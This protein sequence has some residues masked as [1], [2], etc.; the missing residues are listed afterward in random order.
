[1]DTGSDGRLFYARIPVD[2]HGIKKNNRP[3]FVTKRGYGV[4]GTTQKFKS[5]EKDLLLQLLSHKNRLRITQPISFDV[6]CMFIFAYSNY[7]TKEGRR[8]KHVGD[9]S[10]ALELPQD[11]LEESGIIA[12]DNQICSLDGSRRIYAPENYLEIFIYPF[13]D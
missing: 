4:L 2:K 3:I 5:L 1:M 13:K 8:S 11:L 6:H 12:N 7:Y 9:L 10:N